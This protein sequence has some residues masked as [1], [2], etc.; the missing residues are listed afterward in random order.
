M[1]DLT[2]DDYESIWGSIEEIAEEFNAKT[3]EAE[4][5]DPGPAPEQFEKNPLAQAAGDVVH[6]KPKAPE[7]RYIVYESDINFLHY[8]Y[9]SD[10]VCEVF[11]S[12]DEKLN[13]FHYLEEDSEHPPAGQAMISAANISLGIN[14]KFQ[15]DTFQ[16]LDWYHAK[17]VMLADEIE[18]VKEAQKKHLKALENKLKR[19]ETMEDQASE[20]AQSLLQGK[21]QNVKM[22]HGTI[23]FT[24]RK[25]SCV[26][27]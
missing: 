25:E 9:F 20:F 5:P 3:I 16:K 17:R 8:C 27:E 12:D 24:N 1:S 14:N 26:L 11:T 22:T 4:D 7:G 15:I 2:Q 18:V 19:L 6:K 21:A 23:N 10:G 13:E